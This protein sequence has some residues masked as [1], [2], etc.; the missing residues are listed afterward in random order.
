MSDFRELLQSSHNVPA[1]PNYPIQTTSPL[2]EPP[3]DFRSSLNYHGPAPV[4]PPHMSNV[5]NVHPVG[6]ISSGTAT[7]LRPPSDGSPGLLPQQMTSQEEWVRR[8]VKLRCGINECRLKQL[9]IK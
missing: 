9:A 3:R 4:V 6:G 1:P 5:S 7:P 8:L 2:P